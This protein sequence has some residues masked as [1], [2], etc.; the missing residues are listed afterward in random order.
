VISALFLSYVLILN[1]AFLLLVRAFTALIAGQQ[2]GQ[3]SPKSPYHSERLGETPRR[4][5]PS[6]LPAP[7][8]QKILVDREAIGAVGDAVFGQ[9]IFDILA[10]WRP[11]YG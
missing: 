5:C 7:Y 3:K 10:G 8:L 6:T 2:L 11:A 1:F 4:N 9:I